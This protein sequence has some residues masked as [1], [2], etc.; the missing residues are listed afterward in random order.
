MVKLRKQLVPTYTSGT[1]LYA[2]GRHRNAYVGYSGT[3][4]RKWIVIHET[5][6]WSKGAGAAT[7]ANLQSNGNSRVAGWHYEVDDS[8]AVQSFPHTARVFHA[9]NPNGNRNGIGIEMCV[10][11]DND[12]IQTVK[13]TA[14]LVRMIMEQENIPITNVVQHNHFSG[15]HCPRFLREGRKGINWNDF[16]NLVKGVKPKVEVKGKVSNPS[17]AKKKYSVTSDGYVG[18]ETVRALQ[19]Y[20]GLVV[21]GEM[22]GQVRNQSTL[23]FNQKAVRYG[24]G[25]SP[26]VRALQKKIGTTVDGYWGANTTRALQRY[27]GTPVDGEVWRPSTAIKEMQRRLNAGTF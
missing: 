6:N 18:P 11:S 20:F 21:D 25:G 3:N 15:K 14:E 2:K 24:S 19:S 7:H 9:G 8:E 13:N 1:K 22:W 4:G 23:A 16:I 5:D 12:Y 27:L 17:A 10:N 26:V